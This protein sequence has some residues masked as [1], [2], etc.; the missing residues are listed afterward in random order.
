MHSLSAVFG[1]KVLR[2]RRRKQ[3]FHVF[4]DIVKSFCVLEYLVRVLSLATRPT[5]TNYVVGRFLTTTNSECFGRFITKV[6]VRK[7]L[8][9]C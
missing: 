9:F 7:L 3:T 5:R 1:R 4:K 2:K 8:F 6:K